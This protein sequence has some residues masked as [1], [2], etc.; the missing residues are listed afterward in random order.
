[1]KNINIERQSWRKTDVGI[2][3]G[4]KQTQRNRSGIENNIKG[5]RDEW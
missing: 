5:L 3:K 1:M 2:E 4:K